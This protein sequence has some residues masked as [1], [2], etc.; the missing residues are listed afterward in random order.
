MAGV[1]LGSPLAALSETPSKYATEQ[2]GTHK[3]LSLLAIP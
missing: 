1:A 3:I 2:P